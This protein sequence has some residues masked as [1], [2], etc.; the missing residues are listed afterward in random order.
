VRDVPLPGSIGV[1][2]ARIGRAIMDKLSFPSP[3]QL[4][5]RSRYG[6]AASGDDRH[7]CCKTFLASFCA[8][9]N[10]DVDIEV[11]ENLA[12]RTPRTGWR[13]GADRLD[14]ISCRS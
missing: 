13:P 1:L 5:L 3:P 14:R 10:T 2:D 12:R 6:V 4:L 7:P 9:V 8:N 11:T